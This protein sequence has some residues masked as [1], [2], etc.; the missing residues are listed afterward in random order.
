MDLLI[1]DSFA[2]KMHLPLISSDDT[3]Q[4]DASC[5]YLLTDLIS[6]QCYQCSSVVEIAF[7]S[8]AILNFTQAS[9]SCCIL[10]EKNVTPDQRTQSQP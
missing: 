3:D 8:K 4:I 9:L 1:F 10:V 7:F 2:K 5:L 6:Y